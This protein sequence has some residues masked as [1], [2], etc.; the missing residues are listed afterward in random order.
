[1]TLLRDRRMFVARA[2]ALAALLVAS[3]FIAPA[4]RAAVFN[5]ESFTLDNGMQVVVVGNHRAPVVTHMVWYRAGAMDEPPGR[6]GI[7]HLLEHLMF[8][9][10]QAYPDGEFSRIVARNGGRENA[11]TSQDFT[12][13]FQSV[14][15]DRLELMMEIESDRMINLVLSQEDLDTERQVVLEERRSR[16]DNDPSSR[17]GEQARAAMYLNHPYGNPVI[18][19]A[20]EIEALERD[21]LMAYYRSWYAPNNAILVIVGDTTAAQV[22]PL[23]EKYYGRI[24]ARELPER[25]V[26]REPPV[27]AERRVVL[28]DAQVR[29][30]SW[31]RRYPAPGYLYGASEHAY[32]LEVLA[33]IL[34]GGT[35][36]R[37]YKKLVVEQEVAAGAGVWYDASSRGPT[38]F[39]F[40][41]SPRPG[42][43]LG[44]IEAAIEAE[45]EAL[46]RDGVTEDE[47][48]RAI[49]HMQAQ[50]IYARDSLRTP[51]QVL[52]SS[53]VIGLRVED[54]EAW[55]ERIGAVTPDEV[56]AAARAVLGS[57]AVVTSLLLPKNA[58]DD[59][60]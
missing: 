11:F 59:G 41:G 4:A 48:R 25:V 60:S 55:P 39:G 13:Y 58:K 6:T 2:A 26:W 15:V 47:V 17:L 32:A 31:T 42:G 5:P 46:L 49:S 57:Q 24:P 56:N 37:I 50:A 33:E 43:E 21:D 54:V 40:Y 35:T 36:G 1:M 19:W 45:I 16:I 23:A 30:P 8:K 53:L 38:S 10:T 29:Q 14:A 9:G 22:R 34:G 44:A 27:S 51:A 20:H 28:A 18:G 12:G 3:V 52:G 7:A